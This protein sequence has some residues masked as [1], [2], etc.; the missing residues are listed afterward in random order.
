MTL[1][2][3]PTGRG[4]WRTVVLQVTGDRASPLL[5]RI[6]DRIPLGGVLFRVSKVLA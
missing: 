1:H 2:L 6:G 4:R 3:V 5:V